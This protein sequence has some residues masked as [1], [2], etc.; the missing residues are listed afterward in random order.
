MCIP[1]LIWMELRSRIRKVNER[2]K[3]TRE[4]KTFANYPWHTS[5]ETAEKA[6]ELR[7]MIVLD[8]Y[9]V[10]IRKAELKT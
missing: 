4:E 6:A 8:K 9:E 2:N 1:F 3:E 7:R 10:F 5:K